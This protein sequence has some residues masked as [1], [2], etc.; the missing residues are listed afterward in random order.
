MY[1]NGLNNRN[2]SNKNKIMKLTNNDKSRQYIVMNSSLLFQPKFYDVVQSTVNEKSF[3]CFF[4]CSNLTMFV[5]L[6]SKWF[7]YFEPM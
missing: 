4:K 6:T 3:E 7:N 1:K 2:Q 5:I